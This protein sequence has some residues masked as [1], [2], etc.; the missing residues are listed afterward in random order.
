MHTATVRHID[1]GA[2]FIV[3]FDNP[4]KLRIHAEALRRNGIWIF[5]N[6]QAT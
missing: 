6:Q 2:R 4:G 3:Y 1:D 5:V